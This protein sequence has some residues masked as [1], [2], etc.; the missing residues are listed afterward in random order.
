[1]PLLRLLKRWGFWV[2]SN[3]LLLFCKAYFRLK[4]DGLQNLPDQGPCIFVANHQSY[5]DILVLAMAFEKRGL[6]YRIHWVIGK[7]TYQNPLLRLLFLTASLIVVNGTVKK[8]ETALKAGQ[9]IVIF[10]EGFYA[11]YKF[12]YDH[13]KEK[14]EPVRHI[15]TSAAILGLKTGCPIIPMGLH[16]TFEAMPPFSFFPKRGDLSLRIGMPFHFVVPEPEAVTDTLISEESNFIMDQIGA[17][18]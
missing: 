6:L 11:W 18:R 8:A 5:L 16:G 17:L 15:G 3:S 9:C 12:L 13:G 1:M 2:F 10:P 14:T 4:I 7:S